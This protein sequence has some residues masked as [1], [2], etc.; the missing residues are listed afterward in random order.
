MKDKFED[1]KKKKKG[2]QVVAKFSGAVYVG[3]YAMYMFF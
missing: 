3:G 2:A 1:K